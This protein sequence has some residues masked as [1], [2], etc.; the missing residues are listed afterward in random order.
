VPRPHAPRTR[1][2]TALS[3]WSFL[4]GDGFESALQVPAGVALTVTVGGGWWRLGTSDKH[5][6]DGNGIQCS[7]TITA[8][9]AV[10]LAVQV[11]QVM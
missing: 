2:G 5:K 1:V 11:T 7:H 4:T 9:L 10:V 8:R 3:G 6:V